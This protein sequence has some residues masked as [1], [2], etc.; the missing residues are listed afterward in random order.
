MA[1]ADPRT[2][3]LIGGAGAGAHPAGGVQPGAVHRAS[4][5]MSIVLP[6]GAFLA[7]V[8]GAAL[9]FGVVPGV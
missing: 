4:D 3:Y 7:S 1:H 2:G 8:V 6:V 5:C 9:L